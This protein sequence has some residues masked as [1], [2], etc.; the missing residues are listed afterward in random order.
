[1]QFWRNSHLEIVC[2]VEGIDSLTGNTIQARHSYRLEDLEWNSR[3][4]KCVF[5]STEGSC[6]I[7]FDRFHVVE[8]AN[9][10]EGTYE[11]L[12]QSII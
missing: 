6:V 10:P 9:A 11:P 3:F 7:D 4:G 8:P 1:M 12:P 2:L 5:R